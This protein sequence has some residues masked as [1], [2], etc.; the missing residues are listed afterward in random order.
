MIQRLYHHLSSCPRIEDCELI[1]VD[2][3]STDGT[4]QVLE[5]LG[6]NVLI[7]SKTSRAAQMNLG[8]ENS[9][10]EILWF[11]HADTLPPTTFFED[12]HEAISQGYHRGGYAFRFESNRPLLILNS[13]MTRIN[14]FTFRGGDQTL[15]CTQHLWN[16]L[17]GYD[18]TFTLMEEYDFMKRA[19]EAGYEHCLIKGDVLV[20]ARKYDH[21]SY[22]KVQWVNLKAMR[23]F[24][25]GVPPQ[26]IRDYYYRNLTHPKDQ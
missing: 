5:N 15:F 25:R 19:A 16:T 17:N 2:G 4:L 18:E 22:L 21:N 14:V 9:T 11:V 6:V 13:L 1:I 26:E 23:M 10:K 12:I 3:G 20:S 24:N 7:S 8:A